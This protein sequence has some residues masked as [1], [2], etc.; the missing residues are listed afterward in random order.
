LMV[1]QLAAEATAVQMSQS[2]MH[3]QQAE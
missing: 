3:A 2:N 1:R